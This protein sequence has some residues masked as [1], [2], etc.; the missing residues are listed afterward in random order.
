MLCVIIYVKQMYGYGIGIKD[1]I[2]GQSAI[3]QDMMR[4]GL[5]GQ[6][7]QGIADRLH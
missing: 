1:M 4:A 2:S 3:M 6:G 7:K 5:L